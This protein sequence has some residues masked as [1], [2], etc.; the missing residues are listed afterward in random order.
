MSDFQSKREEKAARF[1]ELAEKHENISTGRH[2]ATRQQLEMIPL[3]QPILVGHHSERRHRKDLNSID[4]HLA[5]AKEHHDTA[6]YYRG[7]AAAVDSNR[8]TSA[9]I[10]TRQK[11]WSIRSSVLE[12]PRRYTSSTN[13]S[14]GEYRRRRQAFWHRMRRMSRP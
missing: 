7:R 11:S 12:Q 1:R 10:R 8:A 4:Q 14:T 3:G 13:E 2:F 5:K 9:M 6:E